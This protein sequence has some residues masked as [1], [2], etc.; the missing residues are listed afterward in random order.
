MKESQSDPQHEGEPRT[1]LRERK[2]AQ[3]RERITMSARELFAE[4]GYDDVTTSELAQRARVGVGTLFRYVGSKPELLVAI[5]N[6]QLENGVTSALELASEGASATDAIIELLRPWAD[7]CLAHPDNAM[8]Y[9]RE[10]LFGAGPRRAQAIDQLTGLEDVIATIL[11][12][13]RRADSR[14][15]EA[16]LPALAHSLAATLHLDI[17]RAGLGRNSVEDLP[18]HIRVSLGFLLRDF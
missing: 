4:K 8:A 5:M 16:D 15:A 3:K 14:V 13:T 11:E 9:Q 6:E 17:V 2:M 10:V 18:H 1:G 7:E 12:R